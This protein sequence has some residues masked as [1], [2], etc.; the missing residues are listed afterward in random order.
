MKGAY[1][2]AFEALLPEPPK[3]VYRKARQLNPRRGNNPAG[4]QYT[5]P[6]ATPS[7][8]LGPHR[9]T[10]NA[11]SGS[12]ESLRREWVCACREFPEDS[13]GVQQLYAKYQAALRREETF[14]NHFQK[15]TL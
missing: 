4:P 5:S 3:R 12:A 7:H 6:T 15:P 1:T 11:P 2:A 10:P 14:T 9:V 8:S 13:P